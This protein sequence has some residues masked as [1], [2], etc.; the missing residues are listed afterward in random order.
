MATDKELREKSYSSEY[1]RL[2]INILYTA[3]WLN[4]QVRV[5]LKPFDITS[6]QFNILRILRGHKGK[7]PQSILEIKDKMIDRMS[8]VSRLIDRLEKKQ[9]ISRKNCDV[10]RRTIR[11]VITKEGL[12]LLAKIDD[13]MHVLDALFTNINED[14]A[15]ALN[16]G[17]N[18]FRI[19]G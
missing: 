14:E 2:R 12:R 13:E 18:K 5:F 3:N 17:L 19:E 15:A 9:L 11:I 4:S 1:Q 16:E 10:D 7:T 8:D 6:K